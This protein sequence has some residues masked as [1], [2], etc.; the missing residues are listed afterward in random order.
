MGQS[1]MSGELPKVVLDQISKTPQFQS[2]LKRLQFLDKI[3]DTADVKDLQRNVWELTSIIRTYERGEF[4]ANAIGRLLIFHEFRASYSIPY[5]GSVP[6]WYIDG[7]N[8]EAPQYREQLRQARNRVHELVTELLLQQP[9]LHRDTE[10]TRRKA[11]ASTPLPPSISPARGIE[12][13]NRQYEK[14]QSLLSN[15]PTKEEEYAAWENIT[16][17]YLS[18]SF[19]SDSPNVR[20]VLDIGKGG[21]FLLDADESYWENRRADSLQRQLVMIKGLIEV[22]ETELE[23]DVP[24]ILSPLIS[25]VSNR[26]FLVHGRND[27]IK[28]MV[29]R[30]LMRLDV[31]VTILHEQPNRGRTIIEKFVDHSKDVGFAVVLLTADDVGGL[32]GEPNDKQVHRARQN[33]ILELGFFLGALGRHRVCALYESGVEI[34]SDFQGVLFVPLGDGN[35]KWHLAKEMQAA[36]LPIDM[37]KVVG[38]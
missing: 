29:A 7:K 34:P 36:G 10:M 37:N 5:G 4:Y 20:S 30:F 25:S 27:G 24:A 28:E 26:V 2:L 35:W 17:E 13:L 9:S 19:G 32:I 31:E 12:L 21:G 22:L 14:G 16:R 23:E 8:N 38:V 33:V 1:K 18:K 11:Q 3:E 15:R 6:Q